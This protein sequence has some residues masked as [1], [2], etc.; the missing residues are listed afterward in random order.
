MSD[1]IGTTEQP[2]TA[3]DR[4]RVTAAIVEALGEVLQ[5]DL[6]DVKPD[7]GLFENLGLDSTGVLDLLLRLEEIL[8]CE[9]D[10]EN[11]EMSDFATVSS[12]ADFLV[13]AL[14]S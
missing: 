11:L 4:T 9:F 14:D 12:L 13:T 7:T 2:A 6:Q 1:T 5:R 10:T 3:T 8:G